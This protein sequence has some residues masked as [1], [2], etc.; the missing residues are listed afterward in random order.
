MALR[1]DAPTG[2]SAIAPDTFGLNFYAL[3]LSLRHLL[4]LYLAPDLRAHLE[5]H[6]QQLGWLAANDLDRWAAD[7]DRHPPVLHMRDRFGRDL[8]WIEYH[9]SYR[10]LERSPTAPSACMR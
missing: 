5:P 10:E 7:A 6:L 3:D 9:P 8:Q 2:A 4:D 1:Q